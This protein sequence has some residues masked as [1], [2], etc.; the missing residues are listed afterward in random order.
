MKDIPDKPRAKITVK[1]EILKD[2]PE[3]WNNVRLATAD[4]FIQHF[5]GCPS[6]A[7]RQEEE[8]KTIKEEGSYLYS[9]TAYVE[10]STESTK[11]LLE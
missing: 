6:S 3:T 7:V 9:Q 11:Q 8:I 10:N 4:I 2:F 5:P 1:G